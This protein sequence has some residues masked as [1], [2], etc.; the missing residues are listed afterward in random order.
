MASIRFDEVTKVYADGTRAVDSLGLTVAEGEFMVLVGPSG[1]GKT[2]ALRMVAGLEDISEGTILVGDRVVNDVPS[3]D[4]DIAMVFQNYALYPHMT[5]AQNLAFGLKLRRL[6]GSRS[7]AGGAAAAAPDPSTACRENHARSGGQRQRVAG[8]A[9][10]EPVAFPIL[11]SPIRRRSSRQTRAEI[12]APTQAR[13]HDLRHPRPGRS[14]DD[15]DR[16]AVM[17]NGVLQQIGTPRSLHPPGEHLATFIG[18]SMNVLPPTRSPSAGGYRRSRPEHIRLGANG[19]APATFD[20]VVE[21]VE[22]L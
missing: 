20:A 17:R 8:R 2:T 5:V 22:Y 11:L 6:S 18:S 9:T 7:T 16:I 19:T 15:G 12:P 13:N 21:V 1:C 4:R 10:R 14:D 3:K